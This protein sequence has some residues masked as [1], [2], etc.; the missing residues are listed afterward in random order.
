[1]FRGQI[2]MLLV[3]HDVVGLFEHGLHR[4]EVTRAGTIA[5]EIGALVATAAAEEG[6]QNASKVDAAFCGTR[7]RGLPV[8]ISISRTR[9]VP[10][11]ISRPLRVGRAGHHDEQTR[12]TDCAKSS[13]HRFHRFNCIGKNTGIEP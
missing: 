12:Q 3:D 7:R 1:M 10:G 13:S 4:L 2:A 6:R 5:D 11:R 9:D 8:D